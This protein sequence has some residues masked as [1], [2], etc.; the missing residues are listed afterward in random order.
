MGTFYG[1]KKKIPRRIT[2]AIFAAEPSLAG[3][4]K[5][6]AGNVEEYGDQMV[7]YLSLY[8]PDTISESAAQMYEEILQASQCVRSFLDITHDHVSSHPYPCVRVLYAKLI[9][10][11][12]FV[13]DITYGHAYNKT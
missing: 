3:T 13:V 6:M 9:V 11:T 12:K 8:F 10:Y 7:I 1:L 4:E 5:Y 2:R